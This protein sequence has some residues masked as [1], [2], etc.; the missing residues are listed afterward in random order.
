MRELILDGM[1]NGT[2]DQNQFNSDDEYN[3]YCSP[4]RELIIMTILDGIANGTIDQNKFNS[5]EEY[6]Y[7]C[8][9]AAIETIKL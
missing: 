5:D 7:S 1:A 8:F 2:I 6:R 9:D 4:M 3:I